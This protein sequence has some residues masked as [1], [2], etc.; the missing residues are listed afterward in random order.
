M[1][2][3]LSANAAV[4]EVF[5]PQLLLS[6]EAKKPAIGL[7]RQIP[8]EFARVRGWPNEPSTSESHH[9][10]APPGAHVAHLPKYQRR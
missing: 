9:T 8:P 10:A 1:D 2:Q 3:L 4:S 7:V 5:E 6:I